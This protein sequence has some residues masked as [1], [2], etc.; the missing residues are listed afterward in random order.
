[1]ALQ[2]EDFD[3]LSNLSTLW[4]IVIGSV[5]ATAGGLAGSQLERFFERRER[6]R[7]S[8]LL[9]AEIFSTLKIIIDFAHDSSKIGD[10]YG[11]VTMRM[12]RAARRE[13]DLYE[14][15]REQ[16]YTL[17]DPKIRGLIHKCTVQLSMPIDGIF[18]STREL[19]LIE[20]HIKASGVT[21]AHRSELEQR[22]AAIRENRDTGFA[23][24]VQVSEE[25]KPLIDLLAPLARGNFI[26]IEAAKELSA[27]SGP[28]TPA[29]GSTPQS[30]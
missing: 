6:E 25:L 1:M 24:V 8:A 7:D 9:F 20:Q 14:R 5:L 12:L 10:P 27:V 29:P 18:D 28:A 15:N 16:V 19:E 23:F 3:F 4:A 13:L 30:T 2:P 22:L 26:S 17:H 21:E 11:P